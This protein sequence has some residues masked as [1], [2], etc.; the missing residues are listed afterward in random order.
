MVAGLP[1]HVLQRGNNRS[2]CFHDDA[3]RAFYLFHLRRLLPGS[4]CALHAYCL[5][6]NH[7]HLVLTPAEDESCSRLMKRV[8][9]LHSQYMNRRYA[10][11]GT[12][13]DG[14]FKSCPIEAERYLFNCHRYVELNP[15]RAGLVSGPR[16]YEWS[17]YRANA[18]EIA[19]TALTA[20]ELIAALGV[21]DAVRAEAYRALFDVPLPAEALSEIRKATNGNYVLG[22]DSFKR[23]LAAETGIRTA[24]G[25]AGKPAKPYAALPGQLP[26]LVETS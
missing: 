10:R 15:V 13:W 22:G 23:R 6:P 25:K 9:Q 3:D 8:T 11:T 14:R 18:G 19:D 24:P 1:F 20:H 16:E 4:G 5:M 7:V 2:A 12:L 17:S 21:G 26:L